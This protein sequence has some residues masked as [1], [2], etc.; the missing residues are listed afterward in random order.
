MFILLEAKT[1]R[2][3]DIKEKIHNSKLKTKKAVV[4]IILKKY[5]FE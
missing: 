1:M 3:I 2:N 5:G 4:D